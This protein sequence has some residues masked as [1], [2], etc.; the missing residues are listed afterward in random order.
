MFMC[1]CIEICI[2]IERER[3]R[4]RR[5]RSL[6]LGGKHGFYYILVGLSRIIFPYTLL[7]TSKLRVKVVKIRILGIFLIFFL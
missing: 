4:E 6:G 5:L 7:T 2:Y 1:I 3:E